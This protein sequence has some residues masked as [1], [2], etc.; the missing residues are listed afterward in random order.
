VSQALAPGEKA[1]FWKGSGDKD[2]SITLS[3]LLSLLHVLMFCFGFA[4]VSI[5]SILGQ[6]IQALQFSKE[7]IV[8]TEK[9]LC[10]C[11]KD[12]LSEIYVI[13]FSIF[14]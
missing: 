1:L 12:F 14:R 6:Q 3:I 9:T 5:N 13:S 4:L 11:L 2:S 8:Q 7:I 10:T